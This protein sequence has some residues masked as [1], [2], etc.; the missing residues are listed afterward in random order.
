[1]EVHSVSLGFGLDVGLL[2][3]FSIVI[4]ITSKK[5]KKKKKK[6]KN[7]KPRQG[8]TFPWFSL[9]ALCESYASN[10]IIHPLMH[11]F[12]D[13]LLYVCIDMHL[14]REWQP[15]PVTLAL[16]ARACCTSC[17]RSR[18]T[19]RKDRHTYSSVGLVGSIRSTP[20]TR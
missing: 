6:K 18:S 9:V 13:Q 16:V 10:N 15:G 5:K 12:Q 8:M 17:I 11:I 7:R 20:Q 2:H 4:K 1:M 3:V 19:V 14:K